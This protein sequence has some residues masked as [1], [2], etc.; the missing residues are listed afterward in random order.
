MKSNI[1]AI[2]CET[3]GIDHYHGARPFFVTISDGVETVFWEWEVDPLTRKVE[4][5]ESEIL[6]ISE[7]IANADLIIGQNIKFDYTALEQADPRFVAGW[8]WSKVRDTLLAGHL[9]ASNQPHDLTSMALHYLG[10]DIE[11]AEL[12]LEETVQAARRMA[13]SKFP[14][15]KIAREGQVTMPSAREKTWKF[16]MWLPRA[17]AKWHWDHPVEVLVEKPKKSKK[18]KKAGEV[19]ESAGSAR[20]LELES[21]NEWCPPG[22][23]GPGHPWWTVLQEYSTVDSAVTHALWKVMWEEIKSR[24]LDKIYMERLKVLPIAQKMEKRGITLNSNRLYELQEQ[25]RAESV[26]ACELCEEIARRRGLEFKMPRGGKND[27]LM[28]FC[29]GIKKEKPVKVKKERKSKKSKTGSEEQDLFSGE[30][31]QS[32]ANVCEGLE[33]SQIV[34]QGVVGEEPVEKAIGLTTSSRDLV[35]EAKPDYLMLPVVRLTE[36]GNPS[37][38]K[39]ALDIYTESLDRHSDGMYFIR[40]LKA[41]RSRDTAV[42]YMDGYVRF[43]LPLERQSGWYVLHPSLNPTGADTLRWSSSN[44]NEMNISKKEGFNLRYCF[45]P[46][47]GREWW[48]LDARGIEDRLPAYES[49]EKDLIDI[50]ENADKPP[51]YGSNHLLRFH[52][53]YPDIWEKEL[54]E[55]G[56]DKVG[57]HCKKKYASTWYQWCKNG[58]FSIQY[59]S[60]DRADGLGTADRAFHKPGAHALLKARLSKLEALNQK[61]IRYAEKFGYVETM[62]DRTVDPDRGYPV[63]CTRTEYG[64]IKPTVPLS[65]HIQSTACWW[66]MK[67]M[68][69]CEAQL[70]EWRKR[71]FDGWMVMQVHDELVFDFP[72]SSTHPKVD[73]EREKAGKQLFRTS[74]L[75][76]VRVLQGLMAQG[77][78]D[79]VP[80]VPTPVGVEYHETSWDVGETF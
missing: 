44:P 12:K 50:F 41:K 68:I 39:S 58:G 46:A 65:Y 17:L 69:R 18:S 26:E 56:F 49:E 36:N 76:R 66:T 28:E 32:R 11:P 38:D 14:E 51:Y 21:V 73:Y 7:L 8:D 43:W 40:A 78:E 67:A 80:R 54:K 31:E 75:W 19:E 71:G 6:E 72:K 30:S 23:R 77:G 53:V 1:I 4:M 45:G 16:D 34:D 2:D 74:N 55:V 25:Y 9:L 15:W 35:E 59:G 62:P 70:Q 27:A 63:L 5:L 48:S 64:K 29:F 60:I 3:L 22:L 10:V 13:R 42:S 61:W 24:K 20:G 52:T 47:P 33:G 57:P 79:F 37:L